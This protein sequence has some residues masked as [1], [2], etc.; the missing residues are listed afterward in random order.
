MIV[1]MD[2]TCNGLW[3]GDRPRCPVHELVFGPPPNA[4]QPLPNQEPFYIK[5]VVKTDETPMSGN[6]DATPT[7][8]LCPRCDRVNAPSQSYCAGCEPE[9]KP[10]AAVPSPYEYNIPCDSNTTAGLTV[11]D[12]KAWQ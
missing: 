1:D 7:G 8:W 9:K 6:V 12:L 4:F 11:K 2:C 10:E 5:L 3:V